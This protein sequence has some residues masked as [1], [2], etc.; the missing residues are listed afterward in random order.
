MSPEAFPHSPRFDLTTSAYRLR[1]SGVARR[2]RPTTWNGPA[3]AEAV[4]RTLRDARA[5]AAAAA[6]RSSSARSLSTRRARL[7]CTFPSTSAGADHRNRCVR[8]AR[9]AAAACGWTTTIPTTAAPWP[10]PC[11]AFEAENSTR[12]CSPGGRPLTARIRSMSTPCTR[13]SP[14]PTR[15]RTRSD[16][17]F[18]SSRRGRR[19]PPSWARAPSSS[20]PAAAAS[21][22]AIPSQVR[23]PG[24][25]TP[26]TTARWRRRCSDLRR[27]VASTVTSCERSR[28]PSNASR[29]TF[30][31][32]MPRACSA[33][34]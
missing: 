31:C 11:S 34:P 8:R 29:P 25:M 27:P 19:R 15:P 2:V 16:S 33:R 7:C 12:W 3:V 5:A 21:S 4:E 22:R 30:T 28:R 26:T 32:P 20:S 17:T 18:R 14:P 6:N 9:A 10:R 13:P 23:R 24:A 1:T